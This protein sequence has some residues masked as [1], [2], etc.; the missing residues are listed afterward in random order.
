MKAFLSLL[1]FAALFLGACQPILVPIDQ[2]TT[3]DVEVEVMFYTS[4]AAHEHFGMID[5]ATGAGTDVGPYTN[6]EV[7]ILRVEWA[8]ANGAIH[9]GDFYTIL[10]R[11]LPSD[12]TPAEAEA[13][14]ARV[15]IETGEAELIGDVIPLNLMGNEINHCG[16][17][18]ATGFTLSNDLGEWFGDT[19]LYRVDRESGAL[20]LIGDTGIERIMDLSF[21][22]EGTLWATVGN[23]LYTLDLETAAPTEVAQITGVENDN[24]I[25]GIGFTSEGVLYAT[26]PY[27]DGLYTI[28]LETGAVTEIGRHG[29][30]IPHGG[31]VPMVPHDASCEGAGA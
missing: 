4:E 14:L 5:L 3:P 9:E 17:M 12:A 10:N 15:N 7:N 26:T 1:L 2:T 8:A 29:F 19:N 25:M 20:T 31:D 13:R 24:E 23:V 27:S 18:F 6:P 11:R 28:D 30:T 21:D 16:E 22:P